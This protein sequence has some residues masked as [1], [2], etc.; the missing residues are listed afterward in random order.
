MAYSA[1]IGSVNKAL[2]NESGNSGKNFPL[3]FPKRKFDSSYIRI[4]K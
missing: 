2:K 3:Q 1:T 4:Q